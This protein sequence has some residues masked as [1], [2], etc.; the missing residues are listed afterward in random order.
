MGNINQG[1]K[2][3]DI[4]GDNNY[5]KMIAARRGGLTMSGHGRYFVRIIINLS[6]QNGRLK[7]ELARL[8]RRNGVKLR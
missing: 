5:I 2:G 1:A 3:I 4:K 7:A 6:E 8:K